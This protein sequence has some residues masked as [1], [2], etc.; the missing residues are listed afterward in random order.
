VRGGDQGRD[1][2][3]LKAVHVVGDQQAVAGGGDAAADAWHVLLD[4]PQFLGDRSL[5]DDW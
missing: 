1:L 2:G 3:R 5:T 4:Q